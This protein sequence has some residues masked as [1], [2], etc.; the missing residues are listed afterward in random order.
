MTYDDIS[1]VPTAVSEIKSRTSA[2]TKTKFLDLELGLPVVSSPMDSVT[3][4]EMAV[5]LDKMKCLGIVNRFDS[6]LKE[7]Q[8][9][10]DISNVKAVS[11]EC[12]K[13][14]RVLS[15]HRQLQGGSDNDFNS[16]VIS[17]LTSI[18]QICQSGASCGTEEEIIT[19]L[20]ESVQSGKFKN[21]L[22]KAAEKYISGMASDVSSGSDRIRSTP[23]LTNL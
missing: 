20:E 21:A 3:G 23:V 7:I 9:S 14:R 15:K 1:L 2:N 13:G 6:S 4:I 8:N 22:R 18:E 5:A 12:D 16:L 19:H 17:Y 10:S 11:I